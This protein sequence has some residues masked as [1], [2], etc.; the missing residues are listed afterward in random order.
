MENTKS[1][2]LDDEDEELDDETTFKT[3]PFSQW[4][5]PPYPGSQ[6]QISDALLTALLHSHKKQIEFLK[7][8]HEREIAWRTKSHA[9]E[10]DRQS[11]RW[12]LQLQLE[13]EKLNQKKI[14][15]PSSIG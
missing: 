5:P 8:A 15:T 9:L 11:E 12:A 13:R 4:C 14:C 2:E 10:I 3:P 1:D 7:E 6:G